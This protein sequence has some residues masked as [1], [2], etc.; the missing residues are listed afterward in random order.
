MRAAII[1]GRLGQLVVLG[2]VRL[3]V[4]L[5]AITAGALGL[6]RIV[7]H[8]LGAMRSLQ[9][10]GVRCPRGHVVPLAGERYTC[11]RCSYTYEGSAL[12]CPNPECRAV[13]VHLD[14]PTCGLSIR[15]PYRW[16]RP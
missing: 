14:C 10:G 8:M 2:I 6:G 11:T 9:G 13:T 1:A 3:A 12:Q 16:G 7:V 4:L 15:N 5:V